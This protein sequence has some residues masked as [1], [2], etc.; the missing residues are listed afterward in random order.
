MDIEINKRVL[1]IDDVPS[2]VETTE[3]VELEIRGLTGIVR[4]KEAL[5]GSQD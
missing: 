4:K 1:A 5:L 3:K 2:Y